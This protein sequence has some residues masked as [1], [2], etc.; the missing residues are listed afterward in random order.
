[1]DPLTHALA[2]YTLKRAAFPRLAR[3]VTIVMVSTGTVADL[4][5]LSAHV[6]PSAYVTWSH[7][8][9][10][11]LVAALVISFL[12]AGPFFLWH[13]DAAE[14]RIAPV[15]V[16]F[17]ALAASL[18][19]L[20]FDLC[21]AQ[22]IML[23]RPFTSRLFVLD[24]IAHLDLWILGI[25][26][27]ALLLPKLASLVGEEIGA[28]S[29]GPRGR[30]GAFFALSVILVYIAARATFHGSAIATLDSRSYRGQSP[31]RVAAFPKSASAF[32]WNGV[33]ET[34]RALLEVP[35][36]VGPVASFDPES[37]RTSYKPEPSPALDAALRTVTARRFLAYAR[38]PK[39]S[40]EK[41]ADVF[42]VR[43]QTYPFDPDFR[44]QALIDV[45]PSAQI[46][47]EVLSYDFGPAKP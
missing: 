30:L 24:W 29:K 47:S 7:T 32:T 43:L 2:S 35:V 21:Q 33:V 6:G 38:F 14:N 13:R 42:R 22:G 16:F 8:F 9:C 39:A 25:L 17:S 31:R 27:V 26:F 19:H 28:K 1:M 23:L 4:D 10:H 40:V 12:A 34:E 5:L 41:T 11:S 45:S 37:A 44:V 18:L 46:L 3:S 20:L 36:S 15:L